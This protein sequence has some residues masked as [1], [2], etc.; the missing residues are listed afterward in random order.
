MAIH[1]DGAEIEAGG[2]T[3]CARRLDGTVMCWGDNE[4]GQLGNG[5][6]TPSSTPVFVIGP[7]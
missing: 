3:T 2:D 7:E 1:D 6:T 4:F 5:T